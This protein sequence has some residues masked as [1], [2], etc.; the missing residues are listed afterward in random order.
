M[1]L[2]K[3]ETELVQIYK[4]DGY[5]D[6]KIER[7]TGIPITKIRK[8]SDTTDGLGREE[9]RQY[10]IATKHVEQDWNNLDKRIQE[11]QFRYDRGESEVCTGRDGNTLILY[12]IPRRNPATRRVPYFSRQ[13]GND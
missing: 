6:A 4:R 12:E 11:A 8:V 3:Q 10:I 1:S 2:S 13:L 5:K 9:L 7:M